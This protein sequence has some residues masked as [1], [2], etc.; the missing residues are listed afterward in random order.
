ML[1]QLDKKVLFHR[2]YPYRFFSVITLLIGVGL[3]LEV[4]SNHP[5][6]LKF[7]LLIVLPL[8]FF[9]IKGVTSK[10]KHSMILLRRE[11]LVQ[12]DS[13][14]IKKIDL[15]ELIKVTKGYHSIKLY[16][17]QQEYQFFYSDFD[18]DSIKSLSLVAYLNE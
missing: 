2:T 4:K 16:T 11:L 1:T 17:K 13:T 8:I 14:T 10:P 15:C 12:K 6:F 7:F 18:K 9:G 3:L 5:D